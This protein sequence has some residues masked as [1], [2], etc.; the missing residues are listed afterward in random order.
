MLGAPR[1]LLDTNVVLD[2][3]VFHDPALK[4]LLDDAPIDLVTHAAVVDELQRVLA[5]PN[6]RLGGDAQSN[7]LQRYRT[8][9]RALPMPLGFARDSLGLPLRFPRCRD[10]DDQVFLAIALHAAA[11]LVSRD[12]AL[13]SLRRRAAKFGVAIQDP[14]WL[15]EQL[16]RL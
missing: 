15:H 13:L 2:V 7:I 1:V 9:A 6:L 14:A 16:V 5:Y 4:P 10:A 12:K 3:L 11:T 8:L